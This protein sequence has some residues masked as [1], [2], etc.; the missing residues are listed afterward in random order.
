MLPEKP[1]NKDGASFQPVL[2]GSKPRLRFAA[3]GAFGTQTTSTEFEDRLAVVAS[4]SGIFLKKGGWPTVKWQRRTCFLHGC[5]LYY[6]L[7]EPLP[8]RPTS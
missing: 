8:G 3:P 1:K 2:K 5:Q 6:F 4:M 7:H